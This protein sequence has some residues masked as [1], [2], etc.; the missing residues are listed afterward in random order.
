MKAVGPDPAT[1]MVTGFRSAYGAGLVFVGVGFIAA[2]AFLRRPRQ[3]TAVV[4]RLPER[5][6]DVA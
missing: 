3:T 4:T 6:R 2:V 1:A 5:H